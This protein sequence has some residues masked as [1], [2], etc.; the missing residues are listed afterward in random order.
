MTGMVTTRQR[1]VKCT[2]SPAALK[3]WPAPL[4]TAPVGRPAA[5]ALRIDRRVR[6]I[7]QVD[8]QGDEHD[9]GDD[10]DQRCAHTHRHHDT[11]EQRHH[12]EAELVGDHQATIERRVTE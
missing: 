1:A 12:D 6:R 7:G 10:T 2:T 3:P 11:R 5:A 4:I 8:E 9:K